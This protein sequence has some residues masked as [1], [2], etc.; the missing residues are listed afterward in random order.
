M[1][2]LDISHWQ[3]GLELINWQ[4]LSADPYDFKFI[5]IKSSEGELLPSSIDAYPVEVFRRQMDGAASVN[6][7]RAPYHFYYYHVYYGNGTYYKLSTQEQAIAFRESARGYEGNIP[8]LV[9]LEDPF[10]Y[11]PYNFLSWSDTASA[12]KALA[13]A[14][15]VNAHVRD[16]CEKVGAL[17]GVRPVI[18]TGAWW[19]NP[20]AYL[21]NRFCPDEL[22]W[23]KS[24]DFYVADYAHQT[25]DIP[26]GCGR[27]VAWQYTSTPYPPVQ[28][29]PNGDHVDMAQWMLTEY[30]FY[31]GFVLKESP[32]IY[33]P[34][35][36]ITDR[37]K[38]MWIDSSDARTGDNFNPATIGINHFVIRGGGSGTKPEYKVFQDSAWPQRYDWAIQTNQSFSM[39]FDLDPAWYR[40]NNVDEGMVARRSN[41]EDPILMQVL[42]CLHTNPSA[43]YAQMASSN[44]ADW[45][46]VGAIVFS[47][48]NEKTHLGEEVGEVWF[49]LSITNIIM[50]IKA[51]MDL[52][53]IP[54]VPIVLHSSTEFFKKY[55][56]QLNSWLTYRP[57]D[58]TQGPARNSWLW[59]S[60]QEW[61]LSSGVS[62]IDTVESC[63]YWAFYN[64]YPARQFV[65]VPDGYDKRILFWQVTGD[66]LYIPIY[67][68]SLKNA[69]PVKLGVGNDTAT[70]LLPL[71]PKQETPDIPPS[72]DPRIAALMSRLSAVEGDVSKLKIDSSLIME[73]L[74]KQDILK[75]E[76]AAKLLE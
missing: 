59:L 11:K 40:F 48:L 69:R 49:S 60:F 24:Y 14:R 56:V 23:A 34:N 5:W 57:T 52:G 54:T 63:W 61:M 73:D 20:W 12:D 51:L 47:Q 33:N 39:S 43:S 22:I 15:L 45:R 65:Y 6:L 2:G 64:F 76:I 10:L 8:P 28:G 71:F 7:Y 55:Q 66:R 44:R 27:V 32:M 17:F 35:V 75:K 18:Y 68:D 41:S 3:E 13:F 29:I 72:D 1:K 58:S 21:V 74:E 36:A 30:D 50:R 42:R 19:W 53:F 62:Q 46:N 67:T 9:D 31:N 26:I 16:Y 70:V 38:V 25:P 37:M 4:E